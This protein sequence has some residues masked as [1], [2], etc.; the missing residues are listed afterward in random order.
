MKHIKFTTK[1]LFSLKYFQNY[2]K[3]IFLAYNF[4][5]FKE[6]HVQSEI[7]AWRMTG[8]SQ[9]LKCTMKGLPTFNT[10]WT[11]FCFFEGPWS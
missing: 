1:Y 4:L 7:M 2:L 11:V 8:Q 10:I 3:Q 5:I 9:Y 6:L